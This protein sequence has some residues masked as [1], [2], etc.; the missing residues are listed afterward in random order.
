[1][2]GLIAKEEIVAVF[3][4]L[5]FE[6]MTAIA[7][8]SFLAFNLLCAP[9]FAAMGAIRREMNSAKWTAFAIGYQCIFAYAVSIMI[10]QF[11]S[12]LSGNINVIGL[13]A[14][15]CVLTFILYMLFRPYKESVKLTKNVSVK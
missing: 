6:G 15:V 3:G 9:C 10:Y 12:A 4:V 5:D 11:G 14:A 8:Y 7:G 1:V 13:V 2:M